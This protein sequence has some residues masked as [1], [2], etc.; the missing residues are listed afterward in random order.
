MTHDLSLYRIVGMLDERDMVYVG[1]R[2]SG[3]WFRL[4]YRNT[5]KGIMTWDRTCAMTD[6][7]GLRRWMWWVA[8]VPIDPD[9]TL[10]HLIVGTGCAKKAGLSG[11]EW[12][13]FKAARRDGFKL[14]NPNSGN[15]LVC[16]AA[17]PR[18]AGRTVPEFGRTVQEVSCH[19]HFDAA[20]VEALRIR[21]E[22]QRQEN[23]EAAER[24]LRW[25]IDNPHAAQ[26]RGRDARD[27]HGEKTGDLEFT[28]TCQR[29][30]SR[31]MWPGTSRPEAQEGADGHDALYKTLLEALVP[32]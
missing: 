19:D 1:P 30:R 6:D 16:G 2:P 31:A 8:V 4:E 10:P 21:T 26:V 18:G 28:W 29:C 17:V 9:S 15:C 7:H 13:E 27:I 24:L 23:E 32:A 25:E 3:W 5:F 14:L 12:D 22:R 11:A 20:V